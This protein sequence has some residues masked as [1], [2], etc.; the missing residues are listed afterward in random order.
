MPR[1]IAAW[2]YGSFPEIGGPQSILLSTI[3]HIK[4]TPKMI[5]QI[6]GNPHEV[7]WDPL[8]VAGI[9][10]DNSALSTSDVVMEKI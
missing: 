6:L 1:R 10:L 3:I 9:D 8:R 5:P 7:T 2:L 4:G